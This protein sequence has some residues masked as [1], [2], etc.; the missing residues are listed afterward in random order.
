MLS[1]AL[2]SRI[3]RTIYLVVITTITIFITI[4]ISL[5]NKHP[6]YS[7]PN[8]VFIVIDA[9]RADHLG[10]N[11]YQRNTSPNLDALAREGV[12][13]TRCYATSSSTAYAS[14]GLM[15]GRYLMVY[16][17]DEAEGILDKKFTTLA[18]YLKKI[19]YHNIAFLNNGHYARGSGF[20]RGF[21]QY[22]S[23]VGNASKTTDVAIDWLKN[24]DSPFFLWLHYIDPHS[25][26]VA[27]P[28]FAKLF[29]GDA[30][31]REQTKELK[32]HLIDGSDP[33]KSQ[34]YIPQIVF[35]QDKYSVGHYVALYDAEIKY[36]DYHIGRLLKHISSNTL[37]V[38]TADHGESMDEHNQYFTHGG[39][40]Y[41]ELLH[42]PLILRDAGRFQR[43]QRISQAISTV[44]IVPT[45][46][47]R[48]DSKEQTFD[49]DLF[50]GIDLAHFITDKEIKRRYLYSYDQSIASIR[51]VNN[52]VKYILYSN[53]K[54]E[55]FFLPNENENLLYSGGGA[56]HIASMKNELRNH[57][58]LWLKSYPIQSDVNP[59]KR[60]MEKELFEQLKSLGYTQ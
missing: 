13:F 54:E 35:Q 12:A 50:D 1:G 10:F 16:G 47:K 45:I 56:L 40:I 33:Y 27:P 37:I 42:V 6:L 60:V 55:L 14:V 31:R 18:E 39:N 30:L 38:V 44:D 51:D 3:K 8:I 46:L 53:G 29:D 5:K 11:G 32:V 34:G 57:L 2:N 49:I 20:E 25:P 9:L 24:S 28:E 23:F 7:K 52:Q 4:C 48:A 26:Y 15:T 17:D 41:D 21:D 36:T 59:K 58:N 19:G 22:N 43:G